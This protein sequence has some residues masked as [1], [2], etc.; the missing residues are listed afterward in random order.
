MYWCVCKYIVHFALGPYDERVLSSSSTLSSLSPSASL[1][2][3]KSSAS[4]SNSP[5]P[6]S[7]LHYLGAIKNN[8]ERML[9]S[10]RPLTRN[11][12]RCCRECTQG[13]GRTTDAHPWYTLLSHAEE[14]HRHLI[15]PRSH[16]TAEY[17]LVFP[18][19]VLSLF[20]YQWIRHLI[21]KEDLTKIFHS[22]SS[23]SSSSPSCF[24]YL[25]CS[26]QR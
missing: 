2:S 12:L 25:S 19:I 1:L 8:T 3:C 15:S 7:P 24:F 10:R 26:H 5:P 9:V 18:L 14:I 11:M 6:L 23:L 20:C 13:G 17:N 22:S 4:S 16:Y 21:S